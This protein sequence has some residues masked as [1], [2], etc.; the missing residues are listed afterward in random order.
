MQP[1]A[2]RPA[3]VTGSATALDEFLQLL[4]HLSTP[5]QPLYNLKGKFFTDDLPVRNIPPSNPHVSQNGMCYASLTVYLLPS[6]A[7]LYPNNIENC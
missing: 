6:A 5:I 7:I 4:Q 1:S 2:M 3:M